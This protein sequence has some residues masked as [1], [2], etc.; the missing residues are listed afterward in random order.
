M[1]GPE[2]IG[3]ASVLGQAAGAADS[4]E[5][6]S[7]WDF[8]VKGG[9]M[10]VPIVVCSLVALS[11]MVE[12]IIS[13]RRSV[14]IPPD[15]L[16]NLKDALDRSGGD[17]AGAMDHCRRNGSPI[18]RILEQG[19]RRLGEPV[20]L[21]ERHIA[22]AGRREVLKLRKFSRLLSVVAAITP[23]MGLLGT[24]FGMIAAFQTVAASGE[25]LGKTELLAGGIYQA[26]ITTA[27]GL[28]VAIPALI[29]FHWMSARVDS[30]VLDMD[31]IT[32]DFVEQFAHPPPSGTPHEPA[33]ARD[34]GGRDGDEAEPHPR[35]VPLSDSSVSLAPAT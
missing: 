10:M 3:A 35:P 28:C 8:L 9:P 7:V 16:P 13:L 2:F 29:G 6:Q 11:V 4:V 20:E 14:I 31:H 5:L 18:A 24:I 26:M 30:L 19:L 21:L 32:A 27:A 17:A 33:P 25:A 23:L 12:R 22:E 34:A 1:N 15:F